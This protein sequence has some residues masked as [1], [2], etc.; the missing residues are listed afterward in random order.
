MMRDSGPANWTN[1]YWYEVGT[2][3][4]VGKAAMIYDAD[5]LGYFHNPPGAP[6]PARSPGTPARRARTAP[7]DQ[8]VDLVAGDERQVDKE[9]AAWLF[10]QWA[11]GKDHL[12]MAALERNMS[13][14][15][16]SRS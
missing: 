9:G 2:D 6:A 10:L 3:L 1:Y 11:T 8:P 5:I 16:A 15:S 13:T 14:R 4:G 7:A 12:R